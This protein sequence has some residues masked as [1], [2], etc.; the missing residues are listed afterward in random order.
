MDQRVKKGGGVLSCNSGVNIE[1][2][3]VAEGYI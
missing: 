3:I 1:M 2:T